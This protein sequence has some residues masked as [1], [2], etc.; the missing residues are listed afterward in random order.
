MYPK[1]NRRPESCIVV[2]AG[3]AGLMAARTLISA[4]VRVLVL[5]KG[6]G[7]GGRMATRRAQGPPAGPTGVWDHGAQFFTARDEVFQALVSAMLDQKWPR[8][9]AM[10]SQARQFQVRRTFILATAAPQA[11]RRSQ[12]TWLGDSK[13]TSLQGYPGFVSA[14]GVGCSRWRPGNSRWPMP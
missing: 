12:S 14:T 6:R 3:M 2:G 9:G 4:G 13:C 1:P 10:A 5:D 7:V 11:W 8:S